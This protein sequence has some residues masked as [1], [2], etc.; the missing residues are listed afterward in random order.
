MLANLNWAQLRADVRELEKEIRQL[1][2]LLRACWL[3]SMAAEQRELL[4]LKLRVTEL[5]VLRAFSRGKL[6][7]KHGHG[8]AE[9]A[10]EYHRRVA[11]R[12]AP[13]YALRLEQSA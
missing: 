6:H 11:E 7:A 5:L 8:S 10:F 9:E 12:V 1:K 2:R 3:R 4:R 13:V